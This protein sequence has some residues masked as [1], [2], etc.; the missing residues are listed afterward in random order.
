MGQ[1]R[2]PLDSGTYLD[3]FVFRVTYRN[4]YSD[5]IL[6]VTTSTRHS[7]G[8]RDM[9]KEMKTPMNLSK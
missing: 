1:I 3:V 6:P 5:S 4:L 2:E 7:C 9:A 8:T